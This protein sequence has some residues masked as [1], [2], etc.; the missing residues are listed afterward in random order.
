MVPFLNEVVHVM[1]NKH[2]GR[3]ASGASD[4]PVCHHVVVLFLQIS[5]N[6]TPLLRRVMVTPIQIH[7]RF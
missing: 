1:I 3:W 6:D 4:F 2:I 7:R 5:F